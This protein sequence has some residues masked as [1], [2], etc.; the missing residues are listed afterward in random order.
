MIA[1]MIVI[2]DTSPLNYFI[3]LGYSDVLRNIYGRVLVPE[4]FYL[5]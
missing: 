3:R 5:K 2:A 1:G 4:L